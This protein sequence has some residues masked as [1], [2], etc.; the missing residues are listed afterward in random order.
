MHPKMYISG[1]IAAIF[2]AWKLVASLIGPALFGLFSTNAPEY[3]GAMFGA[4]I[5]VEAASGA[6]GIKKGTVLI[7]KATA[8]ALTLALP[9]A[10]DAAAGGD[11]G[12]VLFI[13]STTAA[14]HTVTT[15]ATG[16]NGA[17]AIATF[18]SAVGNQI[19]LIAYNG[20]WYMQSQ[21]N[22]TLS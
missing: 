22:I 1:A 8:A 5:E 12:K 9:T 3:S 16:I 7:T 2:G 21:I 11:D 14:A 19:T 20:K 13:M 10:G 17:S 4:F 6:I 18:T 15:P